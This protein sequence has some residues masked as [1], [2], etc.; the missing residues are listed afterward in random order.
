M[1]TRPIGARIEA[2][3]EER[4][5]SQDDLARLFGFKDRQTVSAIETGARRRS[6]GRSVMQGACCSGDGR[7]SVLPGH[8]GSSAD[9]RPTLARAGAGRRGSQQSWN[10]TGRAGRRQTGAVGSG[11]GSRRV[12]AASSPDAAACIL[13]RPGLDCG[14]IP[15][16]SVLSAQGPLP[17]VALALLIEKVW[18]VALMGATMPS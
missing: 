3:R 6:S 16:G 5:L 7:E 17:G 4:R 2:L 8:D 1:T 12:P 10:C 14:Q 11:S 9:C 13:T 15:A 18:G